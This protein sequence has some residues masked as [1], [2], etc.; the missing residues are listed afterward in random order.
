MHWESS[1]RAMKLVQ[2]LRHM[3]YE[4]RPVS[5]GNATLEKGRVRC[6]LIPD[7]S[8]TECLESVD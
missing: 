7:L 1:E 5:L 4:E 2:G 6:D 3:S 8:H